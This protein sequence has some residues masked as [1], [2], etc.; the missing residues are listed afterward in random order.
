MHSP[1]GHHRRAADRSTPG[2]RPSRARRDRA[3][4]L[5]G[6][7]AILRFR[8]AAIVAAQLFDFATFMIMVKLHGI[9]AE[10]NP[11]VQNGFEMGGFRGLFL[12]KLALIVLVS[13]IIVILGR[14]A[15]P[16]TIGARLAAAVTV[17]AVTAGVFGGFSNAI[18]M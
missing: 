2:P 8:L 12:F 14:D 1:S 18:T 10:L 3:A 13:S 17:M 9:G 5:P 15:P 11:L 7:P 6:D 16:R 4:I